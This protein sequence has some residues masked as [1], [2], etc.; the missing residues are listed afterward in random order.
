[1]TLCNGKFSGPF[2]R[3]DPRM[4]SFGAVFDMNGVI[5]RDG[6]LHDAA[7]LDVAKR[8]GAAHL[9]VADLHRLAGRSTRDFIQRLFPGIKGET[10]I[11]A[12]TT[13]KDR[14]YD[15][16][17]RHELAIAPEQLKVPGVCELIGQM[18]DESVSLAL[19]TSA[20]ADEAKLILES[21]G[22]FRHFS[23]ILTHE[24]VKNTK[25]HPEG[26]LLAAQSLGLLPAQCAGFED[27]LPGLESLNSAGF[28][29]IVAVG[30]LWRE[31]DVIAAGHRYDRYI[32]DFSKFTLNQLSGLFRQV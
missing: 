21:F 14:Q 30:S 32:P 19:N 9:T 18:A 16:R 13:E 12:I 17:L 6:R 29:V 5:I 1:M 23:V 26:Y 15:L 28:G 8:N 4:I 24:E 20:S 22:I 3:I 7:W 10:A 11:Q 31:Q 27:S 2:G 25:P